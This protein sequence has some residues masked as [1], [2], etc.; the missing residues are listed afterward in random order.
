[1]LTKAEFIRQSL[2]LHLFFGR[3]MKEHAFF[4]KVAFFPKNADLI[5]QADE[6]MRRFEE[7]LARVVHLADN[8]VSKAVLASGEVVTPYT[9]EAERASEFFTGTDIETDITRRELELSAADKVSDPDRVEQ[10]VRALNNNAITLISE[11]IQFKVFVLDSM[12]QCRAAANTYHLLVDHILREAR[13]YLSLV[14]RL[15]DYKEIDTNI[16]EEE[17]FWN[18]IMAEHSEFIRGLLDPT[19]EDLFKAADNFANQFDEL[20][21]MA[22]AA[23]GS[24]AARTRVTRES[25]RATKR[26]QEFKTQATQG[27]L[28][29]EIKAIIL[30][31]LGD[32]VL[33]EANHFLR[34]L[35]T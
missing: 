17:I 20:M 14:Q 12:N 3:I 28:N 23:Q 25:I 30:P 8:N 35:G 5:R 21:Q 2:G 26:L 34:L 32:H 4:L 16:I 19:E 13:L 22:R 15:Q 33:R 18:R 11:I 29:C 24:P 27:L 6:L 10:L 9:I 31:L 7:F 1:M